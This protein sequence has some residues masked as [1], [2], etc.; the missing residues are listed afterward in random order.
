[1]APAIAHSR[2]YCLPNLG[3]NRNTVE[4]CNV[5]RPG[6]SDEDFQARA[7]GG[8]EQ[9]YGRHRED[10]HSVDAGLRHQREI[11]LNRRGFGEL[12]AVIPL[13]E[14]TIGHAFDKVLVSPSKKKLALHTERTGPIGRFCRQRSRRNLV[15]FDRG[16][17][18]SSRGFAAATLLGGYDARTTGVNEVHSPLLMAGSTR[19]EVS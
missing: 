11:E 13:R 14:G 16:H 4:K 5:L 12:R 17:L 19:R 15:D 6:Q 8:V 9:P 2:G 3:L 1:M 18:G 7:M 10:P